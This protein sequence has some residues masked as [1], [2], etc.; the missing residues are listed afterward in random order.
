M[1]QRDPQLVHEG[2]P[3]KGKLAFPWGHGLV[4]TRITRNR[5]RFPTDLLFQ[6]TADEKTE[7]VANCSHHQNLKFSKALPL[8]LPR[9]GP[10]KH[11]IGFL[12]HKDKKTPK[13]STLAKGREAP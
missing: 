4:F 5:D 10:P 9:M 12:T 7:V 1:L 6:L 3:H 8:P 2:G 13:A 11:P